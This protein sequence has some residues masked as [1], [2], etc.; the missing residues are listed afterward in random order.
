MKW[1]KHDTS[2][3]T[4]RYLNE[5]KERKNFMEELQRLSNTPIL[6]Y[7][8]IGDC[9]THFINEESETHRVDGACL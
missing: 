5:V 1:M 6:Q 9:P 8:S 2:K 4:E 3:E 7:L